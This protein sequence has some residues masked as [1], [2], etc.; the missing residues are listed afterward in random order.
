MN[1]QEEEALITAVAQASLICA[2][3][4]TSSIASN[5]KAYDVALSG[6]VF[7]LA[8]LIDA[9]STQHGLDRET[10][11]RIALKGVIDNLNANPDVPN[12]TSDPRLN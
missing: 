6:L 9:G 11:T 1:Q 8:R 4:L 12:D 2:E 5:G 3:N 10:I 7:G